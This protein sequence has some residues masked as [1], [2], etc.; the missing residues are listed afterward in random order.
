MLTNLL[1]I[2]LVT[3]FNQEKAL[4]GAFSVIVQLHRLIF[5]S[6]SYRCCCPQCLCLCPPICRIS[7]A[8]TTSRHQLPALD[9]T[10]S[11]SRSQNL[12]SS[13]IFM[14]R[15]YSA[16][17]KSFNKSMPPTNTQKHLKSTIYCLSSA[18]SSL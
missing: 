8:T 7:A 9:H 3:A 10:E 14:A 5:Y 17:W 4:V 15:K 1:P 13:P 16:I 18:P 12:Y 2:P 11:L 6:T